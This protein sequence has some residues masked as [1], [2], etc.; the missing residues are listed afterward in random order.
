MLEGPSSAEQLRPQVSHSPQ[1]GAGQAVHG[2]VAI[3]AE[4]EGVP[5]DE[6]GVPLALRSLALDSS[7]RAQVRPPGTA[8]KPPMILSYKSGVSSALLCK[9]R[10]HSL[11]FPPQLGAVTGFRE[12]N[13]AAWLF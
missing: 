13:Q 5:E 7:L 12:V 4:E 6:G 10:A 2:G 3:Q 8:E 1:G 9:P 11:V